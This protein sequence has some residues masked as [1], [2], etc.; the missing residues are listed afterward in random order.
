MKTQMTLIGNDLFDHIC[1]ILRTGGFSRV[2][3]MFHRSK[4]TADIYGREGILSVVHGLYRVAVKPQNDVFN[5]QN[6][7]PRDI[8][9]GFESHLKK[10]Q[11]K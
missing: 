7:S 11:N 6:L 10:T 8:Q 9:A 4:Q 5:D 3:L 1:S 2:K